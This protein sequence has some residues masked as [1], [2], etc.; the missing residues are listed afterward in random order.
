MPTFQDILDAARGLS[1]T[2]RVLLAEA[3]WED[4]PPADW[5]MPTKEWIAEAQR[6]SSE[7]DEGRMSA[8]TWPE[9]QERARRNAGLNE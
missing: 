7:Y 9:V 1:P 5:P 8:A 2:E 3:L 4:L 6:R